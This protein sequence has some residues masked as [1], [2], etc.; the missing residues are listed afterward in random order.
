[1][2]MQEDSH[3]L[4]YA[5]YVSSGLVGDAPL[6]HT[7][8]PYADLVADDPANCKGCWSKMT[9]RGPFQLKPFGDSINEE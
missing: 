6:T 5:V 1:M 9:F 3:I 2:L 4:I 8:G 7:Q